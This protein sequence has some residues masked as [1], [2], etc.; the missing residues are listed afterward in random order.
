MTP[1]GWAALLVSVGVGL[2]LRVALPIWLP[3]QFAPVDRKDPRQMNLS[4]PFMAVPFVFAGIAIA[5]TK[6]G[7]PIFV[8]TPPGPPTG[9]DVI[10]H[11]P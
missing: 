10:G 8:S 6:L 1:V 4:L 9:P 11:G 3:D 7:Y 2:A 5:L